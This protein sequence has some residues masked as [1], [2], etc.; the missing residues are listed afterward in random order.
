MLTHCDQPTY[1]NH[2]GEMCL[3]GVSVCDSVLQPTV[4]INTAAVCLCT[5]THS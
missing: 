3:F 1:R 4:H 5:F 2:Q